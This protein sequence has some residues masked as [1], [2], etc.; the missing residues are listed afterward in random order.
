[1]CLWTPVWRAFCALHLVGVVYVGGMGLC[2]GLLC[3]AANIECHISEGP[4][5][6]GIIVQASPVSLQMACWL[7]EWCVLESLPNGAGCC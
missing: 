7:G 4:C 6:A 2:C 1:M 3:A 5:P